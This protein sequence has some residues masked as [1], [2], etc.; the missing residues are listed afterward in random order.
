MGTQ[1]AAARGGST[2]DL[3]G[4][5]SHCVLVGECGTDLRQGQGG[6]APEQSGPKAS[7]KSDKGPERRKFLMSQ[8]SRRELE[9]RR[10]KRRRERE[11]Q[12]E[13]GRLRSET[14]AEE[15]EPSRGRAAEDQPQRETA[16]T[17]ARTAEAGQRV[18]TAAADRPTGKVAASHRLSTASTRFWYQIGGAQGRKF[19]RNA[20]HDLPAAK[21]SWGFWGRS[22]TGFKDGT[23]AAERR[24]FVG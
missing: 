2:E 10:R 23:W 11:R 16:A 1:W 17:K 15:T 22:V 12:Q 4:I 6:G 13:T 9:R 18:T 20:P 24:W 21:F 19:R 8:K 3:R 7:P 14:P 5:L